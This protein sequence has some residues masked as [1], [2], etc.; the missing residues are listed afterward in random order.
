MIM[1]KLNARQVGELEA[2]QFLGDDVWK[3][4]KTDYDQMM[5]FRKTLKGKPTEEQRII[6][7][8]NNAFID[9]YGSVLFH[10]PKLAAQNRCDC[11][12]CGRIRNAAK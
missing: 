5:A 11:T 6:L 3:A 4:Y 9:F 10:S 12:R 7:D 8:M 2:R 1:L